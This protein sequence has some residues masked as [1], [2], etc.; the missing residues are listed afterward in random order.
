MDAPFL[1]PTKHSPN[2]TENHIFFYVNKGSY[3]V[4]LIHLPMRR[5]FPV[6][7][8]W[9]RPKLA[10]LIWGSLN[11]ACPCD[12][13]PSAGSR[14]QSDWECQRGLRTGLSSLRQDAGSRTATASP[15]LPAALLFTGAMSD[16]TRHAGWALWFQAVWHICCLSH[17]V[18][19]VCEP[20]TTRAALLVPAPCLQ[21]APPTPQTGPRPESGGSGSRGGAPLR[22]TLTE[23]PSILLLCS[24]AFR[25]KMFSEHAWHIHVSFF[26]EL[27][28]IFIWILKIYYFF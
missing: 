1:W 9:L 12:E 15:R 21:T 11:P 3:F 16:G 17:C 13:S 27:I 20:D 14:C 22:H 10:S 19:H 8:V 18:V 25:R 23:S 6:A 2:N 4:V 28:Y 5:P 24:N 26:Y 7:V